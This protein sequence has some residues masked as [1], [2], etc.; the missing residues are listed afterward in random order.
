MLPLKQRVSITLDADVLRK[1]RELAEETDR[2]L[3]NYINLV[4]RDYLK[5]PYLK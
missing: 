2:T 4:L 1:V 3:S 5:S